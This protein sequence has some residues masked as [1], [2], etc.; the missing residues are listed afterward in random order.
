VWSSSSRSIAARTSAG[1]FHS[2]QDG[3]G[4][5]GVSIIPF[6]GS[7]CWEMPLSQASNGFEDARRKGLRESKKEGN[8]N[9]RKALSFVPGIALIARLRSGY[10]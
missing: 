4:L 10:G 5:G 2:F 7:G 3:R 9:P 6:S 8:V 1:V